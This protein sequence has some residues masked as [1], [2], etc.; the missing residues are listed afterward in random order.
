MG[1]SEQVSVE[2]DGM[3]RRW[4]DAPARRADRGGRNEVRAGNG[5]RV[6][7]RRKMSPVH[8]RNARQA[9][10]VP[11]DDPT[12][13][14]PGAKSFSSEA[15]TRKACL[16]VG[17]TRASSSRRPSQI[18]HRSLPSGMWWTLVPVLG[19]GKME[20]MVAR[21]SIYAIQCPRGFANTM[22]HLHFCR[23][24]AVLLC[25]SAACCQKRVHA[26]GGGRELCGLLS[27][28]PNLFP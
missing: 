9:R 24:T 8:A 2:W 16:R 20:P 18:R 26:P 13:T 10:Y 23:S 19:V 21:L 15:R 6:H 25:S 7:A 3:A 1:S 12:V 27:V 4:L 11:R 22:G 14:L 17:G 5:K 28:Q